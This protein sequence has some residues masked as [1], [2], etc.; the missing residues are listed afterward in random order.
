MKKP[1]LSLAAFCAVFSGIIIFCVIF[2]GYSSLYRA[3]N[4]I[5]DAKGNIIVEC[6][7][8][9]DLIPELVAMAG[10]SEVLKDMAHLDQVDGVAKQAKTISGRIN[11]KT[12][13]EKELIVA[14]EKSQ[15][16]LS[17]EI[18]GLITGLKKDVRIGKSPDFLTLEKKFNE[19]EITVF[20]NGTKY[21]KEA[22]Y[23]NTRKVIFPGFFVAKIFGLDVIN[24]VEITTDLFKP[25]KLRS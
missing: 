5:G 16:R 11:S 13:P 20:Y 1:W 7:K 17:Q 25:E 8:R 24:Y 15:V 9:Q 14:F 2:G 21:N 4:R 12:I 3:Q 10:E 23:F 6:W 22:R 19:F 18:I